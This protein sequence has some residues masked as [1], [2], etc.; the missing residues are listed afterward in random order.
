MEK[1]KFEGPITMT[2]EELENFKDLFKFPSPEE[3]RALNQSFGGPKCKS[4]VSV[5]PNP[6]SSSATINIDVQLKVDGFSLDVILTNTRGAFGFKY[7]LIFEEKVIFENDNNAC[8]GKEIIPVHL[9]QKEG[10]Y[11]VAYEI[12]LEGGSFFCQNV[13]QFIVKK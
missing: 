4:M 3:A 13:V 5:V 8:R 9:I 11:I 1:L 10:T 7:K 12:Y 2:D 6:T